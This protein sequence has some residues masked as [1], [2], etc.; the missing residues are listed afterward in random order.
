MEKYF[1]KSY[2]NNKF[3]IS[4][5]TWNGKSKVPD[6]SYSVSD[7]LDYFKYIIKKH[8]TIVDNPPIRIYVN[9]IENRIRFIIKTGCYPE[10][11][12]PEMMKLL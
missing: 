3:K 5:L 11:L 2:K 4:A 12:T 9:K 7:I 10:L 8:E 6:R 1:K